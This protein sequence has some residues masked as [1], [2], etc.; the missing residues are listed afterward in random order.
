MH[1]H[2]HQ[3]QKQYEWTYELTT[4]RERLHLLQFLFEVFNVIVGTVVVTFSGRVVV[5]PSGIMVVTRVEVE[6]L[7]VRHGSP[8]AALGRCLVLVEVGV[9]APVA[10]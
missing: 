4:A 9:G 2:A 5:A 3:Q 10:Y 8:R 1:T 7:R 6:E